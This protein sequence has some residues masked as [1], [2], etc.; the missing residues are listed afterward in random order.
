MKDEK[1]DETGQMPS[2]TAQNFLFELESFHKGKVH[3]VV[4]PDETEAAR[5]LAE[6]CLR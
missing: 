5:L 1:K 4:A 6:H 2:G 3:V